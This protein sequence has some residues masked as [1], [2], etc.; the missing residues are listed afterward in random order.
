MSIPAAPVVETAG[1]L[2]YRWVALGA[3]AAILA[4]VATGTLGGLWYVVTLLLMGALVLWNPLNA[5]LIFVTLTPVH[6]LAMILLYGVVGEPGIQMTLLQAWKE[7]LLVWALIVVFL[8]LDQGTVPVRLSWPDRLAQAYLAL[9]VVYLLFPSVA[10]DAG[11]IGARLFGFR[12]SVLPPLVYLLGRAVPADWDQVQRCL[13]W[14]VVASVIWSL[15]GLVEVVWDPGD[16]L[17]NIGYTAFQVQIMQASGELNPATGLAHTYTT[18]GGI[19]RVG[20][21]FLHPLGFAI[22]LL[23]VLPLLVGRLMDGKRGYGWGTLVTVG[24]LFATVS[25]GP[26]AA[27]V[28]A[29][30]LLL[31]W[32]GQLSFRAAAYGLLA[33][34]AVSLPFLT[35]GALRQYVY[36]TLAAQDAS[37]VARIA[38]WTAR[39]QTLGEHPWLGTGI[40]SATRV[41]EVGGAE[42]EVLQ[43][44]LR[45]GL[46]GLGLYLTFVGSLVARFWRRRHGPYRTEYMWAGVSLLTLNAYALINP[47]WRSGFHTL[48]TWFAWGLLAGRAGEEAGAGEDAGVVDAA[49]AETG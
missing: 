30:G 46:V 15:V 47:M 31:L 13:R 45:L 9:A 4:A 39:L 22:A 1:R 6:T 28:L 38:N 3:V 8:L 43:L 25:R 44:A 18:S 19:R 16:L 48:V 49:A 2:G 37:T 7:V 17:R 5:F 35:V 42:S 29:V 10:G 34:V 32:R 20:S 36:D 41:G 40:S 24:A 23:F 21:V 12:E 33:I 27:F 26:L 11:T 14:L